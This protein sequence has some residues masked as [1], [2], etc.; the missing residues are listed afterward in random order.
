MLNTS[1]RASHQDRFTF[2]SGA[3]RITFVG[4]GGGGRLCGPH[5]ISRG[6]AL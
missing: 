3:G 5:A 2:H 1:N 4:F 6:R